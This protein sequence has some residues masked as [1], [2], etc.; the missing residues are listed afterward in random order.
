MRE[1]C[2]VRRILMAITVTQFFPLEKG[3][4]PG[5]PGLGGSSFWEWVFSTT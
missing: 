5:D 4:V 1:I 2:L 3:E